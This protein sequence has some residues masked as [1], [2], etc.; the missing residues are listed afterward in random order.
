MCT[1]VLPSEEKLEML[2][3]RDGGGGSMRRT[4][5]GMLQSEALSDQL[6][7]KPEDLECPK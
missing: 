6:D 5:T 4:F 7:R 3:L 1:C 2:N